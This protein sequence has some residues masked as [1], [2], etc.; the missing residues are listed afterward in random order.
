MSAGINKDVKRMNLKLQRDVADMKEGF[1]KG[2]AAYN[3]KV[4]ELE[5]FKKDSDA[6]ILNLNNILKNRNEYIMELKELL[7]AR[8]KKI[9]LLCNRK[10]IHRIIK[11]HE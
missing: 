2:N 7:D 5:T 1:V 8:D 10:L 3:E 4:Q 6:T 9:A 11:K